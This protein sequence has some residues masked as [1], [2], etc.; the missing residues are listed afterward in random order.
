[1]KSVRKTSQA[2]SILHWRLFIHSFFGMFKNIAKIIIC[3]LVFL[4]P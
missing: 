2:S 1:M 3:T 4:L